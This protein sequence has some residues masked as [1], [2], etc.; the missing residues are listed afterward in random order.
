MSAWEEDASEFAHLLYERYESDTLED[1]W[2]DAE[3]NVY[4][5]DELEDSHLVNII[6]GINAGKPF[7]GQTWKLEFLEEEL[8]RRKGKL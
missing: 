6:R 8:Q 3:H 4:A 7:Y 1:E 5:L 2:E